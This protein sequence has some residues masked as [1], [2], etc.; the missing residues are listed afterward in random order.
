MRESVAPRTGTNPVTG[1]ALV[2]PSSTD[3]SANVI[4]GHEYQP[5]LSGDLQYACIFELPY[6]TDCST[7]AGNTACDCSGT[8]SE[9]AAVNSPLCNPPGGGVAT[10][11][12]HFAKAY[13]GLRHLE[14]LRGIGKNGVVASIC[15]KVTDAARATDPS[16]GYTPAIDAIFTTV[17]RAL[18]RCLPRELTPDPAT[19]RVP[20]A[21]IEASVDPECACSGAGY[22]TDPI[23]S[24]TRKAVLSH[25]E[26]SGICTTHPLLPTDI[27]CDSFCLCGIEQTLDPAAKHACEN[28]PIE[29]I[30]PDISGYCYI[31]PDSGVGNPALVE[32]C[33][34]GRQ[35]M[36][37]F[38]GDVPAP[39]S[40]VFM[41]CAESSYTDTVPTGP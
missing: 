21:V 6:E 9:L 34:A 25:L 38:V 33:P 36:L 39:R 28:D 12:Q 2:D 5:A 23:S 24:D 35:R 10:S 16:Y 27:P 31:D 41:A 32:D 18:H 37:R 22:S 30:D 1:A 11:V 13:P 7:V 40:V 20:C 15:P 4:N 26:S 17:I 8:A 14:V 29:S 19:Q 3:P